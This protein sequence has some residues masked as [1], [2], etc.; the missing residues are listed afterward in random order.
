VTALYCVI[1]A[2][3]SAVAIWVTMTARAAAARS[4]LEEEMRK[5]IDYLQGETERARARA[6][7]IARDAAMWAAAWKEGRNDVIA[8]MPLIVSARDTAPSLRP[9][10]DTTETA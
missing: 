6:A 8:I 7:Q 4:R 3:I 10:E 2:V 1:C 5:E 9:A